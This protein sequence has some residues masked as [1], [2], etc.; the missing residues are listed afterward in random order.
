MKKVT[1]RVHEMQKFSNVSTAVVRNIKSKI[2]L[3]RTKDENALT[4]ICS[5]ISARIAEQPR[6]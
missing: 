4:A 5:D 1:R 3:T 6:R 2:V